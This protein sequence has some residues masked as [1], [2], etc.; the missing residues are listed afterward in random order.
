[1]RK[2]YCRRL[3]LPLFIL[4]ILSMFFLIINTITDNKQKITELPLYTIQTNCVDS[5]RDSAIR[6]STVPPNY[7]VIPYRE[8]AL[9]TS[10]ACKAFQ[11]DD[12]H[13]DSN[14]FHPKYSKYL[15]GTFH[16]I[17]P[18]A[19]ITFDDV[20][21][22]YTKTLVE[23]DNNTLNIDT[24]F[25]TN[26]T[27]E[28]IPYKFEQGMWHPIGVT[29]VQRTAI[30]VPLQGREYNAKAFL[31]NMH[32]FVRRQQLTY[33]IILIEQVKKKCLSREVNKSKLM[34]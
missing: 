15:R 1:M 11:L 8:F 18:H 32:A 24:T 19:N 16:Y 10:I 20:E 28:N 4:S 3:F 33:T 17:V 13:E 12:P 25:A 30:L 14:R 26:I 5:S 29:S 31:L 2:F 22:F 21:Q 34:T 9:R 23:K 7:L 27:F 6:I